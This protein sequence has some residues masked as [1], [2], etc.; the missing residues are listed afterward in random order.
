MKRTKTR[1][2]ASKFLHG[3]NRPFFRVLFHVTA[4]KAVSLGCHVTDRAYAL[5]ERFA[6]IDV[7]LHCCT[8]PNS[9][10][11]PM[12]STRFPRDLLLASNLSTTP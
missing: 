11:L 7:A 12:Y 9:N 3:Y 8:L 6:R 2:S 1:K 10:D 4:L 5:P